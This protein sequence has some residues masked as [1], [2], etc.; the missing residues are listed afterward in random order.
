MGTI[1][2]LYWLYSV[3]AEE[4]GRAHSLSAKTRAWNTRTNKI[5]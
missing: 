1:P 4:G 5:A 3:S 2:K